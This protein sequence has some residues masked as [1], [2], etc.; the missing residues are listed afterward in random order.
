[1]NV[2]REATREKHEAL[3][4]SGWFDTVTRD[5]DAYA[6]H[7]GRVEAYHRDAAQ[8][9]V[10][11]LD[12]LTQAGLTPEARTKLPALAIERERLNALGLPGV[13]IAPD[14][15][16]LQSLSAAVGYSYVLEGATLGGT[17]LAG[18]I[19]ERLAWESPFYIGYGPQTAAMWRSFSAAT[20]AMHAGLD[21]AA[22]VGGA[23]AALDAYTTRVASS[24]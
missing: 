11:F 16:E 7:L 24:L 6:R 15:P 10:P 19:R 5:L 4:A 3:D 17:I 9:L 1:M 2:L 23:I 22:L 8:A 14:V 12:A 18:R 21:T 13:D 20:E